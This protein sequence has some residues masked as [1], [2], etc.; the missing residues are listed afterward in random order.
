MRSGSTEW[1][2]KGS[3]IVL[4]RSGTAAPMLVRR[5][6][7]DPTYRLAAAAGPGLSVSRQ[8]DVRCDGLKSLQRFSRAHKIAP[9]WRELRSDLP[10][11]D[12]QC[13][14][15]VANEEHPAGGK[16]Q[17]GAALAVA[18]NVYDAGRSRYVERGAVAEGG[19]LEDRCRPKHALRQ[20]ET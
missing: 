13:R 17:R 8:H 20:R 7:T 3:M 11:E 14:E 6:L 2:R 1:I 5:S 9:E 15:R 12:I 19:D 4:K 10:R 16:M 18:W